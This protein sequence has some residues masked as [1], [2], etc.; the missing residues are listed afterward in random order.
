MQRADQHWKRSNGLPGDR[1]N[2]PHHM[3]HLSPTTPVHVGSTARPR[4]KQDHERLLYESCTY[5]EQSSRQSSINEDRSLPKPAVGGRRS[6][7]FCGLTPAMQRAPNQRLLMGRKQSGNLNVAG[8][9]GFQ[10]LH[11]R[12][13]QKASLR[14]TG[15]LHGLTTTMSCRH[16]SRVESGCFPMKISPAAAIRLWDA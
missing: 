13:A 15:H 12:P 7:G 1:P 10:P 14:C 9:E 2:Q 3:A 4:A 6:I 8:A 5:S 11:Q 16:D